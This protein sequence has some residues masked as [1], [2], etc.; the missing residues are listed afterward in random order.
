MTAVVYSRAPHAAH[1]GDGGGW[2]LEQWD[3]TQPVRAPRPAEVPADAEFH[4][5]YL[6]TADQ[7]HAVYVRRAPLSAGT[8]CARCALVA[9]RD[10]IRAID[11]ARAEIAE[12]RGRIAELGRFIAANQAARRHYAAH[13]RKGANTIHMKHCA[14]RIA[15]AERELDVI[16]AK[17]NRIARTG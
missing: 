14:Q 2:D 3:V 12:L 4:H 7:P 11:A 13:P 1:T 10:E 5:G 9:V 15:D 16:L 6:D 8:T 17:A